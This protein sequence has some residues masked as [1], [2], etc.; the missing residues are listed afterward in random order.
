MGYEIYCKPQYL[1]RLA[2][3]VEE[4]GEDLGLKWYSARALMSLRLEKSWGVWSLDYRPDF[5]AGESGMEVF[6]NWKKD[7]VGKEAAEKERAEGPS[8]KLVTLV[9][10]VDGIDVS[11]DEA[12]L[13]DG[14][15]VGYISSG[16]YAHHVK[17]SVALG[18]VPTELSEGGTDLEVEI[19]GEMYRA[20]VQGTPLY[21][22]NGANMRA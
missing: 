16:G 17:K 10:E 2:E 4:A 9:I 13:K 6:I 11:N 18:Y 15:A 12:I 5:T 1:L 20:Q 8:K 21:D 7:F 22:A 3:A 14:E 19:L